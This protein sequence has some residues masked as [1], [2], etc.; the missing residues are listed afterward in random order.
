MDRPFLENRER[1]VLCSAW[2]G[3]LTVMRIEDL[4][5]EAVNPD[6]AAGRLRRGG[7][8]VGIIATGVKVTHIPTELSAYCCT[9]RSQMKN[10]KIALAMLEWGLVEVGW[11]DAPNG[12]SSAAK[13]RASALMGPAPDERQ[14]PR[15]LRPIGGQP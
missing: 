4:K 1:G 11:Q 9:E 8:T 7:Q 3:T 10:K 5:I 12:G 15:P 2:F 14:P 13:P 6:E